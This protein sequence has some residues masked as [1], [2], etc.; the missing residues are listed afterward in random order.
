MRNAT[1]CTAKSKVVIKMGVNLV[2]C[3]S[4]Q[5]FRPLPMLNRQI[6]KICVGKEWIQNSFG[7]KDAEKTASFD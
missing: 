7:S 6:W 4:F 5:A 2:D 1:L 3:F